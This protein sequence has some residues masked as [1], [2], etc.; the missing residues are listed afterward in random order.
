MFF[1][2][3]SAKYALKHF[4]G[5]RKLVIR[6]IFYGMICKAHSCVIQNY[7]FVNTNYEAHYITHNLGRGNKFLEATFGTVRQVRHSKDVHSTLYLHT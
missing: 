6:H 2:L 7:D 1:S 5:I 3:L 4:S